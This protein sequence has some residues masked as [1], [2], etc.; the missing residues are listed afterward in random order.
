MV[1]HEAVCMKMEGIQNPS[2]FQQFQIGFSV[3]VIIEKCGPSVATVGNVI[4]VAI[5][6][7]PLIE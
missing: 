6:S 7:H 1:C 3:Y 4:Q 2:L 5:L